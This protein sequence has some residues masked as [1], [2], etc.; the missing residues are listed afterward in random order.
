MGRHATSTS[1]LSEPPRASKGLFSIFSKV[2]APFPG[3]LAHVLGNCLSALS[4]SPALSPLSPL[5]VR[6]A[7]DLG[8]ERVGAVLPQP[9]VWAPGPAVGTHV[10]SSLAGGRGAPLGLRGWFFF[11]S[12]STQPRVQRA[13]TV[14]KSLIT[15]VGHEYAR[16]ISA[17]GFDVRET[18]DPSSKDTGL[19]G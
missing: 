7:A 5:A 14:D 16:N 4:R 3:L 17:Y 11:F 1:N 2:R 8:L 15:L 19:P 10:M 6:W 18:F 12:A 9:L 13:S